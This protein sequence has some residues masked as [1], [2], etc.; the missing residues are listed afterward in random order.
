MKTFFNWKA[1]CS[2]AN[3][4]PQL[5]LGLVALDLTSELGQN[6]ASGIGEIFLSDTQT[7]GPIPWSL[8]LSY[9]NSD[10]GN[11]TVEACEFFGIP[12][13]IFQLPGHAIEPGSGML[14]LPMDIDYIRMEKGDIFEWNNERYVVLM[15]DAGVA[16]DFTPLKCVDMSC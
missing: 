16:L 9:Q 13:F 12:N 1:I 10:G 11:D 8:M 7:E 4:C 2:I 14:P 15:S 5:A 6:I 3:K